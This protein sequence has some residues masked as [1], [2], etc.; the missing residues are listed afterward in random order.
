MHGF[1]TSPTEG[2][3]VV[4]HRSTTAASCG[5]RILQQPASKAKLQQRLRKTQLNAAVFLPVPGRF[6]LALA[7]LPRAATT[8]AEQA[9][10]VV[11]SRPSVP[12]L[13]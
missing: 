13:I 6:P 2:K 1:F 9:C 5:G 4:F 12:A 3:A 8:L 11:Q 7:S 10:D